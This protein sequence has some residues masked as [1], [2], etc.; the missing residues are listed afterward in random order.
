MNGFEN[1]EYEVNQHKKAALRTT[2]D[3]KRVTRF[4]PIMPGPSEGRISWQHLRI[5]LPGE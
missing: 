5:S 2:D 3:N 4:T 1:Q